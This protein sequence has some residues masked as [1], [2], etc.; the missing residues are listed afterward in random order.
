M[1]P[2]VLIAIPA[3]L[4]GARLVGAGVAGIL[5]A[6]EQRKRK[7]ERMARWQREAD[8]QAQHQEAAS[9]HV[10]PVL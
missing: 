4:L 6:R 9:I 5:V 7:K 3:A 8:I 2:I 1:I 10:A